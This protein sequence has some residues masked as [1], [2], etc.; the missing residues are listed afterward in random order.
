MEHKNKKHKQNYFLIKH[1]IHWP[2]GINQRGPE[3]YGGLINSEKG[4]FLV[5]ELISSFPEIYLKLKDILFK[6]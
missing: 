6:F 5:P 3:N 4:I 1:G 2:M